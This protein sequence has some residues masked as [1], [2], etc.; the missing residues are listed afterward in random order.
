MG[1]EITEEQ[2]NSPAKPFGNCEIHW[3]TAAER[4]QLVT[5]SMTESMTA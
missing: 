3:A 1:P 2:P 4:D 5:D